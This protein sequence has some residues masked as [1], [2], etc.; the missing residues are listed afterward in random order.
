M[1]V[2]AVVHPVY[3]R[4]H[5]DGSR[6]SIG[7][8]FYLAAKTSSHPQRRQSPARTGGVFSWMKVPP[9]QRSDRWEERLSPHAEDF[10]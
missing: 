10:A 2:A 7:R 3:F 5:L 4:V 6:M 1:P 9:T 8:I